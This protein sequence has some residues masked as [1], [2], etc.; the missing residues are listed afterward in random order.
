LYIRTNTLA[1]VEVRKADVDHPALGA[2]P[3]SSSSIRKALN[4]SLLRSTIATPLLVIA[5]VE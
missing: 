5:A 4:G 1:F 2:S 3:S